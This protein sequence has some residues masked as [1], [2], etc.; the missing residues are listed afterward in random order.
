LWLDSDEPGRA[1]VQKFARKL[2]L[3]RCII[4]DTRYFDESGPKDANDALRQGYN[5]QEF[6]ASA[7][8]LNDSKMLRV[9][10]FKEKVL[11]RMHNVNQLAGIQS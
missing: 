9:S 11:H 6:F 1:A 7:R 10:D 3:N 8:T 2:G 4:I 5:F